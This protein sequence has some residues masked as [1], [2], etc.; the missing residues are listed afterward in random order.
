VSDVEDKNL[1]IS[2][3]NGTFLNTDDRVRDYKATSK[4]QPVTIDAPWQ[5]AYK[6]Q[7]EIYQWLL[8]GNGLAV[9]DRGYF[10]YCNGKKSTPRFDQ[11]LDFDISVL[12]YVGDDAWVDDRIK[13]AYDCLVSDEVPD[14]NDDCDFCTYQQALDDVL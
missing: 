12:P 1:I 10:V 11:R 5:D 14:A 9:S 3:G 8:R 4:D 2:C 6:R 13:D 7:M